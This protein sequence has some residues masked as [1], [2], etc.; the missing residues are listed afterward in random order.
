[1]GLENDMGEILDP[2]FDM[3][4]SAAHVAHERAFPQAF[5]LM[6]LAR[7]YERRM[8]LKNGLHM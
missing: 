4:C 3:K 7:S 5:N 2:L 8:D 6:D 1:V